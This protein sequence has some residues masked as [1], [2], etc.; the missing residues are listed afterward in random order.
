MDHKPEA[1]SHKCSE[2]RGVHSPNTC[3]L[4]LPTSLCAVSPS[5]PSF[6]HEKGSDPLVR[7]PWLR[8]CLCAGRNETN[9]DYVGIRTRVVKGKR[10]DLPDQLMGS[11][12]RSVACAKLK[13]SVPSGPVVFCGHTRFATTS[14]AN[15][16]GKPTDKRMDSLH[17]PT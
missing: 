13:Y 1:S 6:R 3:C 16:G 8:S 2:V 12:R 17:A 9:S 5:H 4:P 10:S 15:F 7:L 14:K 11:F